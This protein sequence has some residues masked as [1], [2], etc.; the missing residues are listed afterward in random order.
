MSRGRNLHILGRKPCFAGFFLAHREQREED[1]SPASNYKTLPS[2]SSPACALS[3]SLRDSVA[4]ASSSPPRSS[5][6]LYHL[7]CS[8]AIFCPPP[9]SPPPPPPPIFYSPPDVSYFSPPALPCY[10]GFPA[11]T[12]G[13][14][15]GNDGS[16]G[17]GHSGGDERRVFVCNCKSWSWVQVFVTMIASLF[18]ACGGAYIYRSQCWK[19]LKK[20]KKPPPPLPLYRPRPPPAGDGRPDVTVHH[21]H[22]HYGANGGGGHSANGGGGL[23]GSSSIGTNGGD[24]GG[25]DDLYGGGGNGSF[26]AAS[27]AEACSIM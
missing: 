20:K 1:W 4:L 21:H 9:L 23:D 17:D 27:D 15:G 5:D 3:L 10:A 22:H 18:S 26:G 14:G 6:G 7:R 24:S 25:N 19:S 13:G 8:P 2:S 16:G 11:C 12:G